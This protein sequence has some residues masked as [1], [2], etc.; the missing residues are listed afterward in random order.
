MSFSS[1][2][3][4]SIGGRCATRKTNSKDSQGYFFKNAFTWVLFDF[5]D[6]TQHSIIQALNLL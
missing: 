1:M 4:E 2:G 3:Q 5:L 6:Q